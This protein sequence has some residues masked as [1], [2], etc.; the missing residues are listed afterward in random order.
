MYA[1]IQKVFE[2]CDLKTVNLLLEEGWV[3]LHTVGRDKM[4]YILGKKC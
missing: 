2:T 1:N 3:L 4:K